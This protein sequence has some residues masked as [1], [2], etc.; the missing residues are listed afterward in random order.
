V[1]L[2]VVTAMATRLRVHHATKNPGFFVVGWRLLLDVTIGSQAR[3]TVPLGVTVIAL[4][5]ELAILTRGF[6]AGPLWTHLAAVTIAAIGVV[7]LVPVL[8]VVGVL[9]FNL[10]LWVLLVVVVMTVVIALIGALLDP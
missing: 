10:A 5:L 8:I 7:A 4:A 1:Y 6:M 2:Y 3:M 9:A